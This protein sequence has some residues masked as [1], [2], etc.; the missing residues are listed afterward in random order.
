MTSE[1]LGNVDLRS[2][3]RYELK[4]ID[5]DDFVDEFDSWHCKR[6]AEQRLHWERKKRIPGQSITSS[7]VK[8]LSEASFDLM[9]WGEVK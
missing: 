7:I 8:S 6:P 5:L 1:R 2:V 9:G 3:E 4:K